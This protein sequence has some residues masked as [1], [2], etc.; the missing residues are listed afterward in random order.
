M[1]T[2]RSRKRARTGSIAA[3]IEDSAAPE[4]GNTETAVR[5]RDKEFWHSDGTIILV[6]RD[7]EFR[8]FKGILA[9]HS[10]VFRDMFSLPQPVD[11]SSSTPPHRAADDPCPIVHLSDSPEDLRHV[12]RVYMPKGGPSAFFRSGPAPC[13]SYH[14]ISA[15]VRLGHKYQMTDLLDNALAYLKTYYTTDYEKWTAQDDYGPPG[16]DPSHAIGVVNLSRLTNET[17]LLLMALLVCCSL[18]D[19]QELLGGFE[20]EDGARERLTHDDIARCYSAKTR[21]IAESTKIALRACRPEISDACK[22]G[23][24]CI[25]S[26]NQMLKRLGDGEGPIAG[27]DPSAGTHAFMNVLDTSEV[28][29]HC[30]AMVVGRVLRERKAAWAR[31]PGYL[32]SRCRRKP[33]RASEPPG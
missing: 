27:F 28:C 21:L 30:R 4:R 31:L 12:L 25:R 11:A 5:K 19:G 9:E 22:T 33:P 18:D 6:A 16:F 14:S 15:A 17:G 2:R 7:I 23:L 29:V 3:F 13:Y 20:R 26:F 8:V 1:S 24:S 32:A 10:P